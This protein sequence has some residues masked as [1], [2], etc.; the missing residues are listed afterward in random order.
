MAMTYSL[1]GGEILSVLNEAL[2]NHPQL[3]A[4]DVKIGLLMAYDPT[5]GGLKHGG[6]PAAA[7]VRIVSAK[8]RITK[9][10]DAEI[11]IDQQWWDSARPKHRVA[12][13]D[14]ECCHLSLV[15]D[16]FGVVKR[17]DHGRPKLRLRKGDWNGG[18]G[19]MEVVERHGDF[20]LEL[21]NSQSVAAKIKYARDHAAGLFDEVEQ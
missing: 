18:D 12:C 14:H 20:S 5:G 3:V 4:H 7:T 9:G 19:F 16:D 21:A 15:K 6:Y 8:D 13:L 10:Y 11:C 1:A 2:V 17:D